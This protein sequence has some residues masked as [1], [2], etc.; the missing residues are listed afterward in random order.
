MAEPEEKQ[1]LQQNTE[2]GTPGH[3]RE[4]V[5]KRTLTRGKILRTILWIVGGAVAAGIIAAFVFVKF[6]P[7]AER[8]IHGDEPSSIV[9]PKEETGETSEASA[10]TVEPVSEPVSEPASASDS[11]EGETPESESASETMVI[12]T[13]ELE[14][15]D[16]MQVM[17]KLMGVADLAQAS[18]VD[19]AGIDSSMDYFS[20]TRE[21]RKNASGLIV[22]ANEAELYILTSYS[23]IEGR[24]DVM[25]TFVDNGSAPAVLKKYDP[26]T[27]LAIITVSLEAIPYETLQKYAV[28]ELGSTYNVK[29]GDPVMAIGRPLGYPGSVAIGNVT[30]VTG[31]VATTDMD[32]SLFYTDIPAAATGGGILIDTSGQVVG[33][34]AQKYAP[35]GSDTVT[36]VGITALKGLIEDLSN[37]VARPYV[38]I[39][40]TEV[41]AVLSSRTDI[42]MGVLVTEVVQDSPAMLSGIKEMD[43]LLSIA[44]EETGNMTRFRECLMHHD[45]GETVTVL[46]LRQGADGY[47]EV[48]FSVELGSQ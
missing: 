29:R 30:S 44:G 11:S 18:V 27:G 47:A 38:G 39:K 13:K 43:I 20:K 24:A 48:E 42:P 15:A 2:T 8:I 6:L 26:N 10:E 23:A 36:A 17:H 19:V 40:G 16:Y 7:V 34:I 35:E 14:I 31:T 25:V 9:I 45:P 5:K 12:E 4:V 33:I 41:T 32:Y 21:S 1:N 22:A 46:A 28:A 3:I 37:G